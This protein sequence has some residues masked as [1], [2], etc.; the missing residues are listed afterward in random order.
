MVYPQGLG[1][2]GIEKLTLLLKEKEVEL[3][4]LRLKLMGAKRF[5]TNMCHASVQTNEPWILSLPTEIMPMIL[6]YLDLKELYQV[7]RA[8][9]HF[10]FHCIPKMY[11]KIELSNA[12]VNRILV[13]FEKKPWFGETVREVCVC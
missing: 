11:E 7:S 10:Y 3:C 13:N 9:S 1:K 12:I 5:R 2:E 8:S 6:E 4:N